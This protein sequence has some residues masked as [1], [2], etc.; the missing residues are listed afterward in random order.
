MT[1]SVAGAWTAS[2]VNGHLVLE[3]DVAITTSETDGYTLKTPKELDTTKSWVLA[4]NTAK[5]DLN[6]ATVEVDLWAG[7]DVDF[8]LSGDGAVT[9]ASGFEVASAVIS[10]VKYAKAFT[11]VDPNY[12]GSRVQGAAETGGIVNVG[13][14]PYY[15][16]NLDGGGAF[17]GSLNCHFVITQ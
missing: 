4:V 17:R 15:A 16:I 9:A 7:Y 11:R 10:E 12:T 8:A 6:A 2:T 14:A 5:V 1:D 13:T 3:C